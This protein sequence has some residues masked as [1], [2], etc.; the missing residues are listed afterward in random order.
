L[1]VP[2]LAICFLIW[3][4]EVAAYWCLG[5]AF[6]LELPFAE[7]LLVMTGANLVLSTPLTPGH[8]GPYQV[9]VTEVAVLL[10]IDR[11]LAGSYAIGAHLLLLLTVSVMGIAAAWALGLSPRD[12]LGPRPV[13]HELTEQPATRTR[14]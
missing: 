4:I 10:G 5:R 11:A 8:V 3:L 6:G 1:A 2:V 14:P 12:L 7:A 9:A 13:E